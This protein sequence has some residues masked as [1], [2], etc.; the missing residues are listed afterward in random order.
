MISEIS[1]VTGRVFLVKHC[2]AIVLTNRKASLMLLSILCLTE[3]VVILTNDYL[4]LILL[5][6]LNWKAVQKRSCLTWIL[7]C[8]LETIN[9]SHWKPFNIP[10]SDSYSVMYL[11]VFWHVGPF[12]NLFP[13]TL[14]WMQSVQ[15]RIIYGTEVSHIAN[16][17]C[18]YL[19]LILWS[20]SNEKFWIKGPNTILTLYQ[21]MGNNEALSRRIWK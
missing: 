19:T 21:M 5:T 6:N 7:E 17:Y 15:Y 18:I 14:D 3:F 4:W 9:L 16:I 1:A 11:C 10:A 13:D 2:W 12:G 20:F 8:C